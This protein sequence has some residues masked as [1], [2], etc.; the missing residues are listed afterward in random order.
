VLD[1]HEIFHLLVV[2]TASQYAVMALY[3]LT[4]A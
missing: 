1:Y 4:G 3:V 2:A